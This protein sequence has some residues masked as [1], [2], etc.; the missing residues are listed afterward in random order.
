MIVTKLKIRTDGDPCL[1]KKS[2]PVKQIG[3]AERMLISAMAQTMYA[4]EGVGLAAPQVGINQR[5]CVV[6]T[7]AE[8]IVFINPE[9]VSKEGKCDFDEGCLSVPGKLVKISRPEKV[10]VKFYDDQAIYQE[11]T[12]A[13]LTAR[14][15]QHEIDHLNGRLI[16]DYVKEGIG[17]LKE[18]V[19]A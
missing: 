1:R 3:V 16:L 5:I 8:L 17:I 14:A 11:R 18:K 7:G 19:T 4:A 9:I 2:D 10:R 12:L 13:G 15:I 6:D